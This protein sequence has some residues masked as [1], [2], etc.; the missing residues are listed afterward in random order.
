MRCYTVLH[1]ITLSFNSLCMETC[2]Q[3]VAPV[4][5]FLSINYC[6]KGCYEFE[7]GDSTRN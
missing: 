5:G 2:Y 7:L 6:K 4:S 1:G 3:Q